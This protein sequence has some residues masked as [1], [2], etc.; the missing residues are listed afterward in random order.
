M[1]TMVTTFMSE[2][3]QNE[4]LG[5]GY[6]SKSMVLTLM[7]THTCIAIYMWACKRHTFV[8]LVVQITVYVHTSTL[9][10]G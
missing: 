4:T 5:F 10:T 3:L 9:Q 6:T 2:S 8:G 1:H 7:Y